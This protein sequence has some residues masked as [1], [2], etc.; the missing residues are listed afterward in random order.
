M[1]DELE[2]ERL[3]ARYYELEYA[4]YAD[5]IDFYV[6]Y[7][8]AMDPEQR[9]PLL[10]LGC[11][12]GR[13]SLAL[14]EAG[15]SVVAVDRSAA[16]IEMLDEK[17][18]RLGVDERVKTLLGDMA[19]LAALPAHGFTLAFCALNTFA[20]LQ[21][22]EEQIALLRAVSARLIQHGILI[23]DLTAPL[24]GL[25]PPS[26]GELL[27]QGSFRDEDGSIVHKF[28]TGTAEDSIQSHEVTIF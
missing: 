22:T 25:L 21:T 12:T 5:D 3:L 11:G 20:Y 18:R 17:A 24:P 14:A 9:L 10:E 1:L 26:E 7:A 16:M 23:L 4:R 6:Q 28:V 27:H 2:R 19:D 13:V 8:L 15:F